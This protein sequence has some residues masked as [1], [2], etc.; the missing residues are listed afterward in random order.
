MDDFKGFHS[1][2]AFFSVN[3]VPLFVN[4]IPTA[5]YCFSLGFDLIQLI[6]KVF[7]DFDPVLKQ[8]CY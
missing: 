3:H 2:R 4:M 7:L 5:V 1:L 8:L 6:D